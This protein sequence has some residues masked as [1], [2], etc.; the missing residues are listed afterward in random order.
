MRKDSRYSHI[1]NHYLSVIDFRLKKYQALRKGV[2]ERD[3]FTCY[4]CGARPDY[5]PPDYNG[6]YTLWAGGRLLEIDH[7]RPR[8]FGGDHSIENLRTICN[9]CN[10]QKNSQKEKR[11]K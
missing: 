3:N 8:V 5:I 10:S 7:I 4:L 11:G 6:R 9:S 2:Y 1:N